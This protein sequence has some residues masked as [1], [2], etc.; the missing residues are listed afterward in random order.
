MHRDTKRL[1]SHEPT[2]RRHNFFLFV[3]KVFDFRVPPPV[4]KLVSHF[5]FLSLGPVVTSSF[6]ACETLTHLALSGSC[7]HHNC[8]AT[9]SFPVSV[10]PWS[11]WLFCWLLHFCHT[12]LFLC[13]SNDSVLVHLLDQ[14]PY[15]RAKSAG[16]RHGDTWIQII[17]EQCFLLKASSYKQEKKENGKERE[18]E[19]FCLWA[20]Y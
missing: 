5:T 10:L 8:W 7:S 4:F 20:L 6:H 16:S 1:Q 17:K 2:T 19:R 18:S 15:L 9:L 3:L 12:L 11:C 13:I 14:Q